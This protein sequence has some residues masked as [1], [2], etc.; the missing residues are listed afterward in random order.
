[1]Y[2]TESKIPFTNI[3]LKLNLQQPHISEHYFSAL[4]K[5]SNLTKA[6]SAEILI[7]KSQLAAPSFS[8]Y[9]PTQPTSNPSP[10]RQAKAELN[11]HQAAQSRTTALQVGFIAESS[12]MLLP[13][14]SCRRA[15][16][17]KMCFAH[18]HFLLALPH[19]CPFT[20]NVFFLLYSF[21]PHVKQLQTHVKIGFSP[22][23]TGRGSVPLKE[24]KR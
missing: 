11:L 6:N 1:M 16:L 24:I 2:D 4:L 17:Q 18:S 13:Q 10:D 23:F 19:L 15:L 5:G 9:S 20:P 14:P 12:C 7:R 3:I 22:L 21:V 8:C